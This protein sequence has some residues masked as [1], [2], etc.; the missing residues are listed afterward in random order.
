VNFALKPIAV[1][2]LIAAAGLAGVADAQVPTGIAAPTAERARAEV[3][4]PIDTS[5]RRATRSMRRTTRRPPP[6]C[7]PSPTN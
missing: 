2:V 1:G 5:T 7:A 6:S 3:K 4:A